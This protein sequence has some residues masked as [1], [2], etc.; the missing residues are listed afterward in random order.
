MSLSEQQLR[1]IW[2]SEI[3]PWVFHR[4]Q[5][6]E[7]PTTVLLGGQPGAGK[8][9]AAEIATERAGAN[10]VPIVG[11]EY[12]QFHPDYRRVMAEDPLRMPDVTAE[13]AGKWIQMCVD[14]AREQGYSTLIEGTWRNAQ[15]PL[16]ALGQRVRTAGESMPL[17]WL[18]SQKSAAWAR[19]SATTNMP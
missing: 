17:S 8:S 15:V 6:Q 12:R 19:W 4:A 14:H 3:K 7:S 1:E 10:V 11:D 13:A 9:R 2:T 16:R 18:F 5:R